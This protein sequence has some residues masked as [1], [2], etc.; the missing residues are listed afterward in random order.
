MRERD[1]LLRIVFSHDGSMFHRIWAA[2][3]FYTC[4]PETRE[5]SD[6]VE[7]SEPVRKPEPNRT[8]SWSDRSTSE[9][10]LN[11]SNICGISKAVVA[12]IVERVLALKSSIPV[13]DACRRLSRL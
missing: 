13:E 1:C 9:K 2:D 3:R 7:S 6:P 10:S 5:F 12:G 11:H 4:V 8:L